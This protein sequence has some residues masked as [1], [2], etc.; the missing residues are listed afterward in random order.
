MP[1][2]RLSSDETEE[3]WKIADKN[4]DGE[5]TIQELKSGVQK[6]CQ[7]QGR[8][9]PDEKALVRMFMGID[10]SGNRKISEAEFM[11]EL[12]RKEAREDI[13]CQMFKS[14]D[15]DGSGT[16]SR[17]E[18]RALF[19]RGNCGYSETDIETMIDDCDVRRDGR[20]R[21]EEFRNV[22]N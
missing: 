22:M 1:G 13:Y 2:K 18:L 20:I 19:Q 11:T 12:M 7:A 5:L 17:N 8:A 14:L 3:F 16:L 4:N 15:K 9:V 21:Y 10:H 6:Y